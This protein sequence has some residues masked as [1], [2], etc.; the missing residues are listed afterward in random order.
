MEKVDLVCDGCK[1]TVKIERLSFGGTG[2]ADIPDNW[3]R[4]SLYGKSIDALRSLDVCEECIAKLFTIFPELES[5]IKK[6]RFG[7]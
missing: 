2:F 6:N 5:F 4:L 3:G 7:L 1:K